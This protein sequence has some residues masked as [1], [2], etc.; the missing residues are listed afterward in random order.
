MNLNEKQLKWL[1][2]IAVLI[3]AILEMNSKTHQANPEEEKSIG[4][5]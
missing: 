2:F 5:L 3:G 1:T 4:E